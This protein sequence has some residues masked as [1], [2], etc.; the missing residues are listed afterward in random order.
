V[1]DN[2]LA[3][4]KSARAQVAQQRA[5]IDKKRLKAPFA[6]RL[7]LRQVDLGQYLSSGT[8]IV[9]L[10]SLDPIFADFYV[11]QQAAEQI[12]PGQAV[13]V[14]VDA[15]PGRDFP[16]KV[17]AVSPKVDSTTRNFQVRAVVKNADRA[18][19]PGMYAKVNV[20]SGA[21][22][23]F[24][25]LPQTAVAYNSYGSTVFLVDDQGKDAKGEPKLVAR[26]VIV[27]TGATRGDQVA[28][29]TGV[30]EGD[31]VVTAGQIKL[32]QGSLIAVNNSV[33][34]LN[35]PNPKPIDQ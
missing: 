28:I 19:L 34:P 11:P 29:L 22:Q 27:T 31:T 23:R 3:T 9:T 18:L 30:K 33:P 5:L 7:G 16:G 10:Q 25:T 20:D 32:R 15:V 26:Q 24:V 35:E 4:L 14:R 12:K 13:K 2:D 1:V 8:L 6:G 17:Q 21:V